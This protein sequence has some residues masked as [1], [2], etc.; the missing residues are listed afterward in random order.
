MTPVELL[1]LELAR[2]KAAHKK[3][4]DLLKMKVLEISK[5]NE[6][7]VQL[8]Q[9]LEKECKY[10][11]LKVQRIENRYQGIFNKL[12]LGLLETDHNRII[13]R[14]YRGFCEMTGYKQE[15]LIGKNTIDVFVPQKFKTKAKK[16]LFSPEY[17]FSGILETTILKKD[18]TL[19]WI[20]I[21]RVPIY[22]YRGKLKGI[23]S[24]NYDITSRKKMEAELAESKEQAEKAR[25][26]EKEFLAKMSHEIRTPLNAI[27]GM[28]HLLS[29][30]ENDRIQSEYISD[31]MVSGN[32]LLKLISDIL[33]LSKIEAGEVQTISEEFDLVGL[34]NSVCKTFQLKIENKDIIV[35]TKIDENIENTVI[36]DELQLAQILMNLVGNAIKFTKKG[37]VIVV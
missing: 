27:I 23:L 8:N 14:A 12:E 9:Q 33:D 21:S 34:V 36:G 31:I 16:I 20:L 22:N 29:D 19:L 15:E 18:G 37:S 13:T 5:T 17:D 32:M 35:E 28:A 30:T 11:T 10:Q 25:E 26:V 3:S 4:E 6:K 1:E 7:L 2:E 24:I